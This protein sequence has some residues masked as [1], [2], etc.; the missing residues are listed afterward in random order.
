MLLLAA[1]V[2]WSAGCV[3]NRLYNREPSQY[4]SSVPV[5]SAV[6]ADL[7]IVE[8]DEF[9]V[10]WLRDQL[11]A[12]VDLIRRRNAEAERGAIV[13]I[14]IHG[15]NHN[16]DPTR[17][18][19]DLQTFRTQLAKLAKDLEAEGAPSPDRVVGVF[20]GWRGSSMRP[21]LFKEASFW[22]RK[23]VATRVASYNVRET[24]FRLTRAAKERVDSKVVIS[25]HSM[26]GLIVARTLGPS[27]S[28]ILLSFGNEGIP[29]LTD[30]VLLQNPALDALS[31][32][33]FIEQLK[34]SN[35]RVE[36]RSAD[37]TIET[38]PGP[39]MASITSEADWVTGLAYPFGQIIGSMGAAT[40][41]DHDPDE[42]SQWRLIT[43]AQGHLDHLVSHT[44]R[45]EDGRV[46]IEAV[47]DA[48]NT[49]PFWVI[50]ASREISRSH[51]DIYGPYF[52]ELVQELTQ[53]NRIY[54]SGVQTW[55]RADGFDEGL[56]VPQP[57]ATRKNP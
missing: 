28:T 57:S 27:L 39:I 29:A 56:R 41:K 21:P 34:L 24:Y 10:F 15:W 3:P 49:T 19:G 17:K 40:R 44:A 31:S 25:G 1:S 8:F 20:L 50:R 37:G 43:R 33:Q 47:P 51:G 52:I 54:D 42:P 22:A 36:L 11:D 53:L 45:V 13:L 4:V 2:A 48:F 35:A 30:L 26:G 16:A 14:H 18:K 23:Q 55:I 46:V 38:A 32:H 7:A 12:A 5:E 6:T 9:G